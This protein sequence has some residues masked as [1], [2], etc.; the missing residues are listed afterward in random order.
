MSPDFVGDV[1][2][3]AHHHKEQTDS[4]AGVDVLLSR[5]ARIWRICHM[6]SVM[7]RPGFR[8]GFGLKEPR[9]S[10]GQVGYLACRLSR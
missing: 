2:R 4:S 8:N 10:R 1:F 5:G 6:C 3:K 9:H 7:C